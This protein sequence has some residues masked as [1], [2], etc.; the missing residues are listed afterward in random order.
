MGPTKQTRKLSTPTYTLSTVFKTSK[1]PNSCANESHNARRIAKSFP[2]APL[3]SFMEPLGV[4]NEALIFV[5]KTT[6]NRMGHRNNLLP[7]FNLCCEW[8]QNCPRPPANQDIQKYGNRLQALSYFVIMFTSRLKIDTVWRWF[9]IIGLA[10]ILSNG[11]T[12]S[13]V[14]DFSSNSGCHA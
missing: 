9:T 11:E 1:P 5:R 13:G 3:V 8:V 12:G 10:N 7:A 14:S 4:K 6:P 2:R